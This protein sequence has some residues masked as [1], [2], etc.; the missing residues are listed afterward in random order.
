LKDLAEFFQQ[1]PLVKSAYLRFVINCNVGQTKVTVGT[2]AVAGS[3]APLSD[4]QTPVSLTLT[5]TAGQT[6]LAYGGTLP[7]TMASASPGQGSDNI[8][9]SGT[10]LTIKWGICKFD[11]PYGAGS[12][13]T[14]LQ[15]TLQN[16][17]LY[18]PLY[19][20]TP[21]AE[22]AFLAKNKTKTVVYRDVFN[23]R[24]T[25]IP[26][27]TDIS[28]LLTNG[29]IDPA[30]II[31]MPYIN[32]GSGGDASGFTGYQSIFTSS[33]PQTCPF[34]FLQNFN[35]QLAGVNTLMINQTYAWQNW[36]DEAQGTHCINGNL[37]TGLTSGLISEYDWYQSP[38]YVVNLARRVASEDVVPKSVLLLGKNITQKTMDYLVFISAT[39]SVTIDMVSGQLLL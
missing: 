11:M 34:A 26:S 2:K 35:V 39:R 16:V 4:N 30:E 15:H 3:Q 7:L 17:R 13:T 12:N 22:S 14:P 25:A 37:V 20:M 38:V 5:Q 23:Y 27:E 18:A 32:A 21:A 31:I 9:T 8:A 10:V 36:V 19:Q 1:V 28:Q 29:I 33:P 6:N 24:V